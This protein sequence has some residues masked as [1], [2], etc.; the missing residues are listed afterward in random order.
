MFRTTRTGVTFI[1]LLTVCLSLVPVAGAE[2]TPIANQTAI[3]DAL[4]WLR[5]QQQ[6]DGGFG[7]AGITCDV[8]L[9][10]ASAG[11]DPAAWKPTPGGPSVMDY[12]AGQTASYAAT[13]AQTG[14]L[15]V[16]V[17]A[18]GMDPINF[19]G[20]D[21]LAHLQTFYDEVAGYGQ[22]ATD[23]AWAILALLA[24]G[25][26]VPE[27]GQAILRG[28]QQENDGWEAGPG[29]GTD[30]NTTALA[31]QALIAAGAPAGSDTILAARDHLLDQQNDDGGFP[32]TKPSPWGTDS[33][34]D[35]TAY[36]IQA[37]MA[38]GED[39]A[40]EVWTR[41]GSD[42]VTAL[43]R[44]QIESG[45]FEWQP[46]FGENLL[47]TAQA[48]PPL[49]GKVLP[50]PAPEWSQPVLVLPSPREGPAPEL[51]QGNLVT[52]VAP[53]PS[54]S[55]IKAYRLTAEGTWLDV[56]PRGWSSIRADGL[57]K[58]DGLPVDYLTF[59]GAGNPYRIEMW[60]NGKLAHSVGIYHQGQ[61][62]F[63]IR[64]EADNY[65]PWACPVD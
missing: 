21:L 12:L 42:P 63:R 32:Y 9:A 57:L 11:Q 17:V 56:N 19:G 34:A 59:G 20:L 43:L 16:A 38:M 24:A 30:T 7:N 22:G 65:T 46:G 33:D 25:Q 53:Q 3:A 44:F 47:A 27:A 40:E 4:D 10:I 41:D 37:L 61:S 15:I 14:K 18:A 23:Q 13:A 45:A 62:L 31:V 50:L 58:I 8:V 1:L 36:V 48:V 2:G 35:S 54:N 29:W 6:A 26:P 5:T 49:A 39:P 28:Y 51:A 60:I 55:W 64:P 52:C